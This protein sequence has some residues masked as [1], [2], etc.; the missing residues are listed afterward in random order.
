MTGPPP[1]RVPPLP[2]RDVRIRPPSTATT[3][4]TRRAAPPAPG[5]A[6]PLTRTPRPEKTAQ[7]QNEVP[8]RHAR[9]HR[10]PHMGQ[11]STP[12]KGGGERTTPASTSRRSKT[13]MGFCKTSPPGFRK[14]TGGGAHPPNRAWVRR[15]S[16]SA[17]NTTAGTDFE[18]PTQHQNRSLWNGEPRFE[19]GP[20]VSGQ[21][22]R[23]RRHQARI[24]DVI[25]PRLDDRG[26]HP[27]RGPREQPRTRRN[28]RRSKRWCS[29]TDRI[30]PYRSS[31][32][33]SHLR[34]LGCGVRAGGRRLR[35]M[36]RGAEGDRTTL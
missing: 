16:D 1:F 28:T 34:V 19:H 24:R 5:P 6:F 4:L 7:N 31:T 33:R 14:A 17:S 26:E 13:S 10:D 2:R 22:H 12:P 32:G 20:G 3:D 9:S 11:R 18:R 21:E 30:E 15:R 35:R 25:A 36:A 27:R 29:D 8:R 23:T